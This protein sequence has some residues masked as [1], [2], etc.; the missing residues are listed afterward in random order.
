VALAARERARVV[1]G[2]AHLLA[3]RGQV[4]V[5]SPRETLDLLDQAPPGA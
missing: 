2:D 3:L 4:P 1:S 5:L